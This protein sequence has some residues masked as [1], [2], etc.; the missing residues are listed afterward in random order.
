VALFM[1]SKYLEIK[2]PMIEDVKRLMECPFDFDEFVEMEKEIFILFEWNMQ[3]P[4]VIE[5][6]QTIL[7]QGVIYQTDCLMI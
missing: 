7:A 5:I 1:S 6:I 3:I 2:Y 4:T